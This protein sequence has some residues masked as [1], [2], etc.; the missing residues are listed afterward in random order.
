MNRFS[1]DFGGIKKRVASKAIK[2]LVYNLVIFILF[3]IIY[4]FWIIA[5][6]DQWN[7]QEPGAGRSFNILDKIF[8]GIYVA[9]ITHTS[10]GYGDYYPKTTMGRIVVMIHALLVFFGNVYM[11]AME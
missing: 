8:I 4:T 6:E 11:G 3:S 10:V 2:M 5:G 7:T 9:A 1:Y